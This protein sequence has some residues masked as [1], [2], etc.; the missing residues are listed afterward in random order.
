MPTLKSTARIVQ[1]TSGGRSFSTTTKNTGISQRETLEAIILNL[2]AY[3]GIEEVFKITSARG[4]DFYAPNTS[5]SPT[6]QS[7]TNTILELSRMVKET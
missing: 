4:A 5:G 3:L 1:A 6:Y 2:A 7:A